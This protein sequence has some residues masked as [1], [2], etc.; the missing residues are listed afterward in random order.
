MQVPDF[1]HREKSLSRDLHDM[2][3]AETLLEELLTIFFPSITFL[4][5]IV[6]VRP[7]DIWLLRRLS[8]QSS[9]RCM[10]QLH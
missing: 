9:R 1:M 7:S 6:F 10:H 2:H 8:C 4:M 5:F 3:L